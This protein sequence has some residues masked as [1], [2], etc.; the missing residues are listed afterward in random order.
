MNA[1]NE[2]EGP[3]N[4]TFASA[5]KETFCKEMLAR[6]HRD[7]RTTH[8]ELLTSLSDCV[9]KLNSPEVLLVV[10]SPPY[11][12]RRTVATRDAFARWPS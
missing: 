9:A 1:S 10:P 6:S 11:R 5:L 7:D 3:H 8:T 12:N 2:L 4:G